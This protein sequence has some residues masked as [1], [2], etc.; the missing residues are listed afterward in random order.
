M[1]LEEHLH[2]EVAMANT[3]VLWSAGARQATEL[4]D[5]SRASH[6]GGSASV[7]TDAVFSKSLS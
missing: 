4:S 3:K 6:T 1:S 2:T 7:C 5:V